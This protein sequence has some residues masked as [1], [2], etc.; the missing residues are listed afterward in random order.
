M[1]AFH[2]TKTF[3]NFE[4]AANGTEISWKSFQKFRKLLNFQNANHSTENFRNSGNKVMERKLL[5]KFFRKFGFTSRGYPLVWKC[6]K[7]V[8]TGAVNRKMLFHSLLE[9]AGNSNRKFWL[10]GKRPLPRELSWAILLFF[11]TYPWKFPRGNFTLGKSVTHKM[12]LP[13]GKE[14]V[15][16]GLPKGKMACVTAPNIVNRWSVK[17]TKQWLVTSAK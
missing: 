2:S 17:S 11:F 13:S 1:G 7:I 3:E 16:Q 15:T 6:R 9:V 5:A 10:N 8:I 12:L 4:T 14:L